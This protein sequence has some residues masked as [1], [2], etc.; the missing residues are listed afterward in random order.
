VL[1]ISTL[2]QPAYLQVFHTR[3][4]YESLSQKLSLPKNVCLGRSI[5]LPTQC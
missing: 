1:E 4:R 2:N 5:K 3:K